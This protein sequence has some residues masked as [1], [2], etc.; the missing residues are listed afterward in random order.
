MANTA[1][2]SGRGPEYLPVLHT[3]QPLGCQKNGLGS[4]GAAEDVFDGSG[5]GLL[6]P[7]CGHWRGGGEN[8]ALRLPSC[9][10]QTLAFIDGEHAPIVALP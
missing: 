10:R 5:K 8:G 4:R 6:C 9:V 3:Q 2:Q 1:T 7:E